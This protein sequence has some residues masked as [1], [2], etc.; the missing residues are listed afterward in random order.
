MRVNGAVG[1]ALVFGAA[2]GAAVPAGAGEPI[3]LSG[4]AWHQAVCSRAIAPGQAR[5]H[6]HVRVDWRG[7]LLAG[8]AATASRNVAPS[9]YAPADL[10]SAYAI[11]AT[12]SRT[13]IVAIV[14]A[15][16]YATAEADLAVYRAQ[17]GLPA[18]T[19]ATGC[20]IKLNQN[21]GTS[22]PGA[23][24]GW[25]QE[26]ALDL[27]M[28]SAMCPNCRIMLVEATN[29]SIAN[30]AAAV[31]LAVA[32]G[33]GVV[34]N[35]YGSSE[36]GTAPYS[37][38]YDHPG[39][40]ITASAGDNGYGAQFPAS[41][42]GSIGV[43]GTQLVRAATARGWSE[44]AWSG[45]GSGCSA[46]YAKPKWQTD[47]LCTTRMETDIAALADPATGVAV[48]GPTGA[49][50]ASGWLIFGGTSV[51]APLIGGIYGATGARPTAA[52]KLWASR[53]AGLNDVTSGSNGQ[54]GGTYFC[55]SAPGFDGPT[56]NGTPKGVVAF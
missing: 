36:A 32:R 39:I 47:R 18:C 12:G 35:S 54:C 15:Y 6:A 8:K 21:G 5:C 2:L 14:A 29:S 11:T 19:S 44:V 51:A 31:D 45:T 43:G 24:T 26:Q 40:A 13:T 23:N 34:S 41:A 48:Y 16:G 27:D 10:R 56:G 49:G 33:A 30:L 9:G 46:M 1:G 20:F 53:A 28:V 17:Y 38:A 42:P 50:T 7:T 22:Y 37:S 52:T 4:N 55:T 25:A 3:E